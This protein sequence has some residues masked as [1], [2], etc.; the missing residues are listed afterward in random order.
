VVDIQ[1]VS[2]VVIRVQVVSVVVLLYDLNFDQ[3][4]ALN[5]NFCFLSDSKILQFP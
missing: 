1:V 5:F 2:V 3:D 4:S